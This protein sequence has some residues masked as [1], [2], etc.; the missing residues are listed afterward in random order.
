MSAAQGINKDEMPVPA[1]TAQQRAPAEKIAPPIAPRVHKIP[2]TTG[3]GVAAGLARLST[4]QRM[5]IGKIIRQQ[6]AAPA[7]LNT[8]VWV[9]T[10][11]PPSVNLNP[12]PVQVT[13]I[14]PGWYG[15]DYVMVGEM[16]LV[17]DP[18]THEIVAI[19][20]VRGYEAFI[21]SASLLARSSSV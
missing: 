19:I 14:Y 20:G 15:C 2:E 3:Q 4:E 6:R 13:N 21:T 1:P 5:M 17:I 11:I 18:S 12:L 7:H 9:G 8:S 10:K 16:I